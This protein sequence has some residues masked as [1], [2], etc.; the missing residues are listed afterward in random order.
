M[1][2]NSNGTNTYACVVTKV[3]IHS[4]DKAV[5]NGA[6]RRAKRMQLFTVLTEGGVR[7]GRRIRSSSSELGTVADGDTIELK[8]RGAQHW[9]FILHGFIL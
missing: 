6:D 2:R 9:S 1:Q 5:V 7:L 3:Y 8:K 4:L